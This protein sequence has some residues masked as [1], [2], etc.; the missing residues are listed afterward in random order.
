[1]LRQSRRYAIATAIL[2]LCLV[3]CAPAQTSPP[4]HTPSPSFT[5]VPLGHEIP[6]TIVLPGALA[7]R[8]EVN[9]PDVDA[10]KDPYRN[11]VAFSTVRYQPY[12]GG[13]PAMLF[14]AYYVTAEVFDEANTPGKPTLYGEEMVRS[15]GMVLAILTSFDLPYPPGTAD[16]KAFEQLIAVAQQPDSYLG[17]VHAES[18][19]ATEG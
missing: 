18:P 17:I 14:N 13:E 7:A 8:V 16:A 11:V 5:L 9:P 3:G 10:Q 2:S 12:G 1:M 15:Q 4:T 19:S 6:Y